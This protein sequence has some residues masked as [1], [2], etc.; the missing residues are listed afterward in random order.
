MYFLLCL[1][2]S[3]IAFMGIQVRIAEVLVLLCF[4]NRRYTIGVTLGC[5]IANLFSPLFPW[6]ILFGTLATLISCL[7]VSFSKHL[8]IATLFPVVINGF[9]IAGELYFLSEAGFW[10]HVGLVSL[11][12]FI[13]VSILGYIIFQIIGRNKAL[14]RYADFHRNL[15]FKW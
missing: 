6:D 5:F 3:P 8:A 9:V 15:D 1:V 14:Q 4:F 11:G 2:S 13:A 12:E 10:V 7:L